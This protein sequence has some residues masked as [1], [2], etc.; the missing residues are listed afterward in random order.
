VEQAVRGVLTSAFMWIS[1]IC[2]ACSTYTVKHPA[3]AIGL[4]GL[5]SSSPQNEGFQQITTQSPT[6][7]NVDNDDNDDVEIKCMMIK[8]K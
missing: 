6:P 1:I 2:T 8:L 5:D 4:V 3:N 7:R